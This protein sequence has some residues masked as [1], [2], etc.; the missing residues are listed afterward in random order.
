MNSGSGARAGPVLVAHRLHKEYMGGGGPLKVL[1]GVDLEVRA[2][3]TVAIVGAS[4]AGKSTL[5]HLL[6]GLDR[7]TAGSVVLADCHLNRL[8][9]IELSRLRSQRLGFVF[10]F[11]HLLL[12]FSALENVAIPLRIQGVAE[13]EACRRAGTILQEVGLGE[14]LTHR[15]SALSGGEQQRV[16]VAR[17]LVH[18]PVVVLADEPSGN[19]DRPNSEHL[20]ELM[21]SLA[22]EKRVAFVVATHD[23]GLARRTDRL[24]RIEDGVLEDVTARPE[25]VTSLD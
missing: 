9:D 13:D 12:E 22:R 4:G 25:W 1:R 2:G 8:S 19:L 5:L 20:H 17:A 18:E 11:H 7:P 15:P 10:Q 3:E 21:F 14:R 6:G 23:E 16:A 24:L